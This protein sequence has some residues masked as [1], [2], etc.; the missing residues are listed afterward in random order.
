MLSGSSCGTT[1]LST[2]DVAVFITAAA[3]AMKTG[4][5][6][7]KSAKLVA[8]KVAQMYKSVACISETAMSITVYAMLDSFS[9]CCCSLIAA[10]D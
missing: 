7:N 6:P 2:A 8:I 5:H 10:F 1:T 3:A 4:S 9:Y